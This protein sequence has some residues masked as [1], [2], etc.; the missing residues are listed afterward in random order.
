MSGR[1]KAID[2]IYLFLPVI[3]WPL[4]FITFNSLFIYAM[5]VA[6]LILAAFT[7]LRYKNLIRWTNGKKI[8]PIVITGIVGAVVL[9][10]VFL[11]G[12]YAASLSGL[13]SY[14]QLVYTMIYSQASKAL[15]FVLLAVIGICEE[16]YWRGG[17]QGYARKHVKWL[18]TMSWILPTIYYSLVHL[19][20][21][22][23]ILVL[24]AFFVG[25]VAGYL[26]DRHG[27]VTSA[28]AHVVWIE[29]VVVFL[30]ITPHLMAML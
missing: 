3:L 8:Y 18:G 13:S 17:V 27:I 6:T 20:T 1:M 16:I 24:A 26:A 19:S 22:N 21:L 9:Y 2:A 5:S 10:L 23:P 11:A 25:L 12:A 4:V 29:A 28:I 14:V 7:L 30:P 15:I